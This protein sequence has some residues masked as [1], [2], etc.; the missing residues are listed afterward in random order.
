MSDDPGEELK[1]VIANAEK[2]VQPF[3]ADRLAGMLTT[4]ST[5]DF[6]ELTQRV[7]TCFVMV[8]EEK[9]PIYGRFLRLMMGCML[10]ALTRAKSA[11]PPRDPVLM[12]ID[13]AAA[14]GR[15]ETLEAGVGYLATYARM[16][17]V[18][19]D[20]AQLRATYPKAESFIANAGAFVTFNLRDPTSAEYISKALGARTVFAHSAGQ[21]QGNLE[22]IR[23]QLNSGMAETGRPLLDPAELLRLPRDQALVFLNDDAAPRYPIRVTKL[24]Y[25]K[26][27]RWRGQW[28][29]W[30]A[31]YRPAVS[32]EVPRPE[33]T[34][35]TPRLPPPPA[36]TGFGHPTP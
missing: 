31:V 29:R 19:Q 17:L 27:W 26:A 3:A 25:F 18:F 9:I 22:L 1:S 8:E 15:I 6:R 2:A 10:M 12:L 5:F 36:R 32:H 13:E 34:L 20:L 28:D 21:S 16:L 7:A 23:Q 24:R 35:D 30:R 14:L 4:N 33:E 11:P